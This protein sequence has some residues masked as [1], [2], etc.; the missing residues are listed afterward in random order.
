MAEKF[1]LGNK[2]CRFFINE[3]GQVTKGDDNNSAK[4]LT[5][6]TIMKVEVRPS[7]NEDDYDCVKVSFPEDTKVEGIKFSKDTNGK[8]KTVDRGH[9]AYQTE[10]LLSTLWIKEVI[11]DGFEYDES[12]DTLYIDCTLAEDEESTDATVLKNIKDEFKAARKKHND[13]CPAEPP[14]PPKPAD[15]SSDGDKKKS[16]DDSDSDKSK[17]SGDNSD[18]NKS[19]GKPEDK[20]KPKKRQPR[21]ADES[22]TG[23]KLEH[24]SQAQADLDTHAT[25]V[26]IGGVDFAKHFNGLVWDDVTKTYKDE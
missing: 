4:Y 7:D 13:K 24:I 23:A 25:L 12:M 17:K 18:G 9:Q 20:P 22:A 3:K 10:L 11:E 26:A 8:T 21:K 5:D 2:K 6:P 15:N 16:G 1:K 14:E 19:K